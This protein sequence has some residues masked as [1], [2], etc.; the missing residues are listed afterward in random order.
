MATPLEDVGKQVGR[1]HP[2]P[3]ALWGLPGASRHLSFLVRVSSRCGGAPC[4]WQT[5]S[6]FSGTSSRAA[7]CW[8]SGRARGWPASSQPPWH[9]RYIVQ[10]SPPP[11]AVGT[12]S[13]RRECAIRKGG[14]AGNWA[15]AAV[16]FAI[17]FC[18]F[19]RPHP[20]CRTPHS[21]R[22]QLPP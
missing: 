20:Q 14:A 19:L 8:S 9:A 6:S 11:R 3:V 21:R 16:D 18:C 4:S 22:H 2:L 5:T 7:P 12:S 1:S 10:V 15:L 13:L 17:P